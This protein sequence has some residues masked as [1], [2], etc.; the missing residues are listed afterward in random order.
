MVAISHTRRTGAQANRLTTAAHHVLSDL[1]RSAPIG[2]IT[3]LIDDALHAACGTPRRPL[4]KCGSPIVKRRLE[5]RPPHRQPGRGGEDDMIELLTLKRMID[6]GEVDL[7]EVITVDDQWDY[8]PPLA[9]EWDPQSM[10][11]I[12]RRL[13]REGRARCVGSRRSGRWVAT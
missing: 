6:R 5:A 3:G 11:P 12:M 8:F 4:Q 7:D 9:T 10:L 1:G 13:R 2:E